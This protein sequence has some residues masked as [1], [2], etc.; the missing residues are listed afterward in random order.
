[1]IYMRRSK[2]TDLYLYSVRTAISV[3]EEACHSLA[4]REG[5]ESGQFVLPPT[6]E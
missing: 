6:K 1:M 3:G 5:E 2:S 4:K